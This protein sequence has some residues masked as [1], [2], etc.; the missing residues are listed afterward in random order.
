MSQP[1]NCNILAEKNECPFPP[2]C[3]AVCVCG[4]T[5]IR[6]RINAGWDCWVG[7]EA[8]Q[9]EDQC[10][11]CGATRIVSDWV[12]YPEKTGT[13]YGKWYTPNKELS[14]PKEATP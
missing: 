13:R 11:D 2:T 10:L 5:R 7:G 8:D 1:E 14:E 12:E 3:S 4:S 9:H 6:R